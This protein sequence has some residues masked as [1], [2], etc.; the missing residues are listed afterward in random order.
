MPQIPLAAWISP[1]ST[2]HLCISI[3]AA[4]EFSALTYPTRPISALMEQEFDTDLS[5][6]ASALMPL[7]VTYMDVAT[8]YHH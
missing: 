2:S 1:H 8:K 7:L 5:H 4:P 6:A 3:L